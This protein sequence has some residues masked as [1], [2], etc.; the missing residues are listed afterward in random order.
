MISKSL[1]ILF[2]AVASVFSATYYVDT[3]GNDLANGSVSTPWKNCP[4]LK[5][6]VGSATL[7]PG[8][9]V[10]FNSTQTWL[11]NPLTNGYTSGDTNYILCPVGGVTYIGD[12]WGG[13]LR[14][15]IR[16]TDT[17]LQ[18]RGIVCF[19][20]DHA[21]SPT[22]VK[23][24][25][26]NGFVGD[27][28]CVRFMPYY[29]SAGS[30]LIGA[31]KR[32]ENCFLDSCGSTTDHY[33]YG[34]CLTAIWSISDDGAWREVR[35]VELVNNTVRAPIRGGIV[36]Y[37]SET[38][39]S[40]KISN[41]LIRG[42]DI[43]NCG[44]GGTSISAG[45]ALKNWVD[46]AVVEYN[47]VRLNRALIAGGGVGILTDNNV[48][49]TVR[50]GTYKCHIRYNIIDSC[51]GAAVSIAKSG[52]HE[53]YVYG[54]I[55]MRNGG[56]GLTLNLNKRKDNTVRISNNI[57]YRNGYRLTTYNG[58]IDF[59]NDTYEFDVLD[60][61]N[62]IFVVDSGLSYRNHCIYILNADHIPT[63]LSNNVYYRRGG[64][65]V[66]RA[67]SDYYNSANIRDLDTK[68]L[69]IFPAF[70]DTS[71]RPTGFTGIYGS[72][73]A[74]NA[75]GLSLVGS[76]IDSGATLTSSFSGS[77]NSKTRP[78]GN[79]WDIGAYEYFNTKQSITRIVR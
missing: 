22:V 24:F 61:S 36:A 18:E 69:T 78:I 9:T 5:G 4:G 72:T 66:I 30:S 2:L 39:D 14:A 15:Q 33:S 77:I 64:G 1:L 54:N 37:A 31:T 49:D 75:A 43:A 19:K 11:R 34:V 17:L 58:E 70:K 45:I 67:V 16:A 7:S 21:T 20:Y 65:N 8:D 44:V 3:T 28:N 79:G 41:I 32:V 60:V 50:F 13:G 42:N 27:C 53:T 35:N 74:P 76:P 51:E 12:V 46:S 10:L 62:N 71:N 57:F 23:G 55:L 25:Y 63:T 29:I 56:S 48:I 73:L 26:L 40:N 47:V 59:S 6:W 52:G 38:H 68:S